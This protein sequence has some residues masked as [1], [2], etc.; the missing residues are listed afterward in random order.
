MAG[1]TRMT[2]S[3]A[4]ILMETSQTLEVFVPMLITVFISNRTAY[5]FTRGLYERATRGKQM[6]ILVDK[7]PE[8][9]QDVQARH[10]M[11]QDLVTF[12]VVTKVKI[13]MEALESGHHAFPVLNM[14]GVPVGL[15]PRNYVLT[16]LE[17]RGFYIKQK[18]D[19]KKAIDMDDA[20]LKR[21]ESVTSTFSQKLTKFKASDRQTTEYIATAKHFDIEFPP[22]P[23]SM[24]LD[25]KLFTRDFWSL[26]MPITDKIRDIGE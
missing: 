19:K 25:W 10:I 18:D 8:S 7:V 9:T 14:A 2:F 1:Y 20:S 26:D 22:M 3:L 5:L 4:V 24:I 23:E 13:I 21:N 11:S 12:K 17:N 15:M 16:I 6:P